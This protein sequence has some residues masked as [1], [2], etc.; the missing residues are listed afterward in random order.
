MNIERFFFF[1]FYGPIFQVRHLSND[2]PDT[3]VEYIESCL[4][5]LLDDEVAGMFSFPGALGKTTIARFSVVGAMRGK[6][7]KHRNSKNVV[8]ISLSFQKVELNSSPT[9]KSVCPRR[10]PSACARPK[11]GVAKRRTDQERW[12]WQF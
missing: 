9:S 11:T 1:Y 4:K 6:R 2:M 5:K 8:F 12:K 7:Y 10:L 3:M